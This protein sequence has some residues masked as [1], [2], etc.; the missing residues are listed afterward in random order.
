[1]KLR[2]MRLSLLAAIGIS[3][4]LEMA[5]AYPINYEASLT[6]N[7]GSGDFAPYYMASNTHGVL[8]QPFDALLRAKAWRPMS[9]ETRFSYGF[10]VDLIG[11]Y[12]SKTTYERFYPTPGGQ[13]GQGTWGSHKQGPPAFWIQQLY[14]EVKFRGVFLT[15][16]MKE[17][18][19]TI[20]DNRLSS[21]DV[22]ESG[23]S[24]P[25]PGGSIGFIDFQNI[26]F[27]N[28]WVQIQGE[29]GYYRSTD[30]DWQ[31]DRFNFYNGH[32]TTGWW[33]NYK[34]CY[35]RTKPSEPL[36][37]TLGMQAAAQFSGKRMSYVQGK[38]MGTRDSKLKVGDFLDMLIPR[39][40]EDYWKGNHVGSWDLK[41]RYRLKNGDELAGYF[42]WLWE[43]GSGIGKLNGLDGLWGISYRKAGRGIVSGA[44]VEYLDFTNQ[45]GPMHWDPED[46]KG[47]TITS[48]ATGFDN[49]YNNFMYAGYSHYGMSIGSPFLRSPLYNQ[50]GQMMYLCNR[51]RGFHLGVEGNIS[52]TVDYRV[53]LSYRKGWGTG[54]QPLLHPW[55]DTSMLAECDYRVPSVKG[56]RLKAQVAWDAGKMYGDNFGAL[57][58]VSYS[59]IFNIGKK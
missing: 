3:A 49:Y 2:D 19:S 26:P 37:V 6:A 24:R 4:T 58:S 27:T 20:V 32:Y 43:D 11:G 42:E 23:N 22:T 36:S 33:Y 46:N 31:H 5:A 40:G 38:Y 51:V 50:G 47:T 48:Q 12:S 59:G 35:F 13:A 54:T 21:G 1:M 29:I 10:G 39:G 30:G 9:K 56:L 7:A 52:D 15:L 18:Q 28:G 34:R 57:V 16:G 17:Y 8:T 44:V 41:A 55:E 25:M 53:L 14:G 45:S